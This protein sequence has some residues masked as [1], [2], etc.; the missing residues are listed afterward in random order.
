[1]STYPGKAAFDGKIAATFS[2]RFKIW[3]EKVEKLDLGG[4]ICIIMAVM[5]IFPPFPSGKK[6][7]CPPSALPPQE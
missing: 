2:H 3:W 4:E 7:L 5:T 6:M 1:M